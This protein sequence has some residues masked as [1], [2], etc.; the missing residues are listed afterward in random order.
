MWFSKRYYIFCNAMRAQIDFQKVY[1]FFVPSRFFLISWLNLFWRAK[2]TRNFDL[3]SSKIWLNFE[4]LMIWP[5]VRL[6]VNFIKFY[7]KIWIIISWTRFLFII[8]TV[9]NINWRFIFLFNLWG[10]VEAVFWLSPTWDL[11]TTFRIRN[12]AGLI[13]LVWK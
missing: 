2:K 7:Q 13:T 4:N 9:R 6:Y 1:F 12:T 10:R 5:P 3:Y 8:Q 11:K